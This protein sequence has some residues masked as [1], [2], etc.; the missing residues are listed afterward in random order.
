MTRTS[1]VIPAIKFIG[2]WPVLCRLL[3]GAVAGVG[4][5]QNVP[6]QK[7]LTE[8]PSAAKTVSG[9]LEISDSKIYY[10]ECGSGPTAIVLIHD[11][12]LHSVT[13]DGIWKPLCAKNHAMRYDRRGYG[14]SD[15]PRPN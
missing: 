12:L 14:R 11:G 4:F 10:E 7:T 9:R 15:A 2:W 6:G 13:W 5:C 1:L 3:L 8:K